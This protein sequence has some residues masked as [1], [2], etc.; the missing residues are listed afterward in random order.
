[1]EGT[2]SLDVQTDCESVFPG[3][4]LCA[5]H[6]ERNEDTVINTKDKVSAPVELSL[7][8]ESKVM[9]E[10][11]LTFGSLIIFQEKEQGATIKIMEGT[12]TQRGHGESQVETS[13]TYCTSLW[14]W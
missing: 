5:R 13:S 12:V 3:F 8:E 10:S 1:M 6:Y 2:T 14:K 7:G 11:N 9:Q 4:L